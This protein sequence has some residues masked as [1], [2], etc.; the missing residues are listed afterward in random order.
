[1]SGDACD[2]RELAPQVRALLGYDPFEREETARVSIETSTSPDGV[3]AH[4]WFDDGA[5]G[6]QGP[7]VVEAASCEALVEAL[8]IVIVMVVPDL[9]T[10]VTPAPVAPVA[11]EPK[12]PDDLLVAR[13]ATL[14]STAPVSTTTGFYTA[15]AGGTS[16][17]G[18]QQQLILGTRWKGHVR[19]LGLELRV[20]APQAI[21]VNAVG[22]ITVWKTALS[23]S[24]CA[25]IG[26]LDAC[27][28]A[29]GGIIR[30]SGDGLEDAR[31]AVSPMVAVGTRLALEARFT[32]TV[33]L[34]LHADA[35]AVL[36]T[37]RFDVDHMAVWVS[38]RLELWAGAGVI[39]LFP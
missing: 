35:Q 10:T 25:H 34:R 1:V 9:L 13:D 26:P 8:A 19:S 21:Q 4:A 30:G 20:G 36:T 38:N 32:P 18:W 39:A 7:R 3:I 12:E 27:A 2:L 6:R 22:S 31:S 11:R 23:I 28:L 17:H 14:T 15:V 33:S 37:T 29:S 16:D 24:P 5:G